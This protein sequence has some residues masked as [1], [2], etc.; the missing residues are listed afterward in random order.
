MYFM[1]RRLCISWTQTIKRHCP[2]TTPQDTRDNKHSTSCTQTIRRCCPLHPTRDDK[3][4]TSTRDNKHSTSWTQTIRRCCPPHPTRDDKHSNYFM[5]TD[6]KTLLPLHTPEETWRQEDTH[7]ETCACK[8]W[9]SKSGYGGGEHKQS[10]FTPGVYPLVKIT[11]VWKI[12]CLLGKS[13]N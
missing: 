3:H 12:T 7:V 13:T 2:P 11:W 8:T 5:D 6:S 1:E 10:G 4:S 9:K